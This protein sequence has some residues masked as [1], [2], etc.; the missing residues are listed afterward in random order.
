MC[1]CILVD[2]VVKEAFTAVA[3]TKEEDGNKPL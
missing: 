2:I 3:V 1:H